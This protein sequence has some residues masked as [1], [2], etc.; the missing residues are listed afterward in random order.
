MKWN[1]FQTNVSNAFRK[2]RTSDNFYDVTLVS[3]DQQQVSAHKLV[4]AR[5]KKGWTQ[6]VRLANVSPKGLY[7]VMRG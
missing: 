5:D 3:D 2:L 1:D 4:L 7:H 6:R